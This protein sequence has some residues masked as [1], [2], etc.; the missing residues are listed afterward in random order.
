[1]G[2]LI[3]KKIMLISITMMFVSCTQPILL[4][5]FNTNGPGIRQYGDT[6]ERTFYHD[7]ELGDSLELV[8]QNETTGSFANFS[9]II[10]NNYLIVH[11][12]A[13]SVTAFD[14]VTGLKVGFNEFDGEI[15]ATPIANANKLFMPLNNFREHSSQIVSFDFTNSNVISKSTIEGNC[16]N[17]FIRTEDAF[18]VL[19][20]KGSLHKFNLVGFEIGKMDTDVLTQCNPAAKGNRAYWGNQN[21]E[22]ICVNLDNLEVIYREKIGNPF[23]SGVTINGNNGFIGDDYGVVTCFSLSDGEVV[24]TTDVQNRIKCDLAIDNTH[25]YVPT[26]SGKFFSLEKT[27]GE[28]EYEIDTRGVLNATPL[29]FKNKLLLPDLNEH[30]YLLDKSDGRIIQS[31]KFERRVKMTP[32]YFDG[33]IYAGADRGQ[34]YA[35]KSFGEQL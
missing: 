11:D 22:I 8:W 20:D 24:W 26:V 14:R 29:V 17:E 3:L 18:F 7:I 31:I 19:S 30:L 25:I 23:E 32:I 13:G 35:F 10:V 1:M 21:G 6:N 16:V 28:I 9:P 15:G 12:L 2:F 33:L 4:K 27:S 5:Y 34:V